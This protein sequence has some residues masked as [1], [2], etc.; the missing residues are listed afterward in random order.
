MN[1]IFKPFAK[2]TGSK[3]DDEEPLATANTDQQPEDT[4]A[5]VLKD[6]SLDKKE[7]SDA[8]DEPFVISDKDVAGLDD[9]TKE[10]AAPKAVL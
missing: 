8:K 2:K 5:S 6:L 7:A 4:L 1:E 10:E 9:S 3:A